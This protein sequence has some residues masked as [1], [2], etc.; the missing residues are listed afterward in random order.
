MKTVIATLLAMALIGVLTA[1]VVLVTGAYNVAATAH[2]GPV[3]W[4]LGA[5]TRSSI[6]THASQVVTPD[7]T[8]YPADTVGAEHFAA[9]C[10]TCHGAPG[11]PRSEAGQGLYPPAPGLAES[12]E[13]LEPA[14][15]YW[16]IKNGIKMTGMPAFG[17]AHEDD[18]LWAMVGFLTKLPTMSPEQYQALTVHDL[19]PESPDLDATPGQTHEHRHGAETEGAVPV[20][21][22]HEQQHGGSVPEAEGGAASAAEHGQEHGGH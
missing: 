5:L 17:A 13:E 3:E 19:E 2:F 1:A 15:L 18:E 9:M 12:A 8:I 4:Y 10:V 22:E 11:V 6:Q 16:V 7:L 20:P 21:A 14:E